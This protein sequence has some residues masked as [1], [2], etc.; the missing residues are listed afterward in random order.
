MEIFHTYEV[1]DDIPPSVLRILQDKADN[2]AVADCHEHDHDHHNN[3][4]SAS[5]IRYRDDRINNVMVG[6]NKSALDA[7][8]DK[9]TE[10]GFSAFILTLKFS[11]ETDR[12]G[13]L[14][15]KVANFICSSVG[16]KISN[17]F[18][19]LMQ[20]EIDLIRNGVDKQTINQLRSLAYEAANTDTPI[21]IL[22][23]GKTVVKVKGSGLGGRN[24]ELALRAAIHMHKALPKGQARYFSMQFLSADTDGQD[25]PTDVA[26]VMVDPLLISRATEQGLDG[27]EYLK[28]DDTYGFFQAVDE[29]RNFVRTGL[30]GT[31]VM[32]IQVLLVKPKGWRDNS[33][34]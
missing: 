6:S 3:N 13:A 11:G 1:A 32:D 26:G 15:S 24:Q 19:S 9:A 20:E 34:C 27:E 29:G 33:L 8:H 14:Y 31:N 18:Q 12:A 17:D 23:G 21:A 25:G 4:L 16:N 2:F 30:T 10:L 5:S 7:A 28:N 22:G